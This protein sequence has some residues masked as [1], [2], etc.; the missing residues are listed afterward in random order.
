MKNEDQSIHPIRYT[1]CNNVRKIRRLKD[2]SQETLAFDA[3]ISR[4][5]LSGIESGKRA[6]SID[7][8]GKIA[9]A[10]GVNVI[11]LLKTDYSIDT[12]IAFED[13]LSE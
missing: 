3:G 10:L 1:F 11:T 6:I 8:M 4:V 13:P 12:I 5:Y 2:I 7:V 9:D